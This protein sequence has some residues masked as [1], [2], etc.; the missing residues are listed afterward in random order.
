MVE[1]EGA[2]AKIDELERVEVRAHQPTTRMRGRIE[3][4]MADLVGQRAAEHLA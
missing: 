1:R 3:Q 4:I 2:V